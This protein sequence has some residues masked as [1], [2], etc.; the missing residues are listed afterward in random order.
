MKRTPGLFDRRLIGT[1]KSD[2]RK[3]FLHYKP[4]TDFTPA[5]TE[6]FKALFGKFTIR[7]GRG[8][9]HT[10]MDGFRATHPYQIVANDDTSVVIRVHDEILD[11]DCLR[12]IHFEGDHYWMALDRGYLSE[13]FKRVKQS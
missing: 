2:R 11:R 8:K 3:T 9:Y 4:P 1:W 7:W 6:K 10:L 5:R 12:Q 13:W